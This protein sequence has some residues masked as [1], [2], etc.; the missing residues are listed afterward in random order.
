MR[1]VTAH[2]YS[3]LSQFFKKTYCTPVSVRVLVLS[4]ASINKVEE[5]FLCWVYA[6]HI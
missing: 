2:L 4:G 3:S 5:K 6:I 1:G